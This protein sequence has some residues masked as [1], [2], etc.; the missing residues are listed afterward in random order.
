[1][2]QKD[3]AM[4]LNSKYQPGEVIVERTFEESKLGHTMMMSG[5][6]KNG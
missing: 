2:D 3:V 1:M 6:N 5:E 4:I